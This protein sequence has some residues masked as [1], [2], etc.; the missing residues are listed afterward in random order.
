MISNETAQI[1]V[2]IFREHILSPVLYIYEE[3]YGIVLV[4]FF[5]KS[6]DD[7]CIRQTENAIGRAVGKRVT[8]EDIRIYDELERIELIKEA[9]I[10]YAE[11]RQ[12]E[13]KFLDSLFAENMIYL[14]NK[15]DLLRRYE[16]TNS[17]YLH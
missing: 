9:D 17:F 16:D 6:V 14:S 8:V 2:D 12:L 4:G 5:D 3:D 15:A 10:S 7:E 11:N 1:I 13:D